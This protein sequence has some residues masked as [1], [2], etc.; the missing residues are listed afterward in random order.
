LL[1]MVSMRNLV[2]YCAKIIVSRI[3]YTF[4]SPIHTQYQV[5]QLHHHDI[6]HCF[7]AHLHDHKVSNIPF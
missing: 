7:P 2:P 6:T 3:W 1:S 5:L 4:Q